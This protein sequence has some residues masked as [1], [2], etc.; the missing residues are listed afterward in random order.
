[1]WGLVVALAEDTC[2][3]TGAMGNNGVVGIEHWLTKRRN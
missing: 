2:K 1:M 3:T